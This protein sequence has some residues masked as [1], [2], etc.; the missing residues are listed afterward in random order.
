MQLFALTPEGKRKW[1]FSSDFGTSPSVGADG[2]IY[3][4]SGSGKIYAITSEGSL[5][6]SF[7]MGGSVSSPPSIAADGTIYAGTGANNWKVV[8][9]ENTLYAVRSSSWGYAAS[10]WPSYQARWM[11]HG[12]GQKGEGHSRVSFEVESRPAE[13]ERPVTTP[14]PLTSGAADQSRAEALEELRKRGIPFAPERFLECG[15]VGDVDCVK[16]FIKAGMNLDVQDEL[17]ATA[18]LR[19]LGG[20]LSALEGNQIDVAKTLLEKGANPD[21]QYKIGGTALMTASQ[22]GRLDF[23]E[24]LL[25]NNANPNVQGP[26]TALG[27]ASYA[28]HIEIVSALLEKGADPNLPG[29]SGKTALMSAS[30][31]GYTEVVK[32]LLEKGAD[33]NLR[34]DDGKTAL[35]IATGSGRRHSPK[36]YAAVIALLN[37]AAMKK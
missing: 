9:R 30:Y 10:P 12:G 13:Q 18:L 24:L 34:D 16:F 8:D 26:D 33:C 28:G 6:W 21:L 29:R 32:I 15:E 14:E 2:T 19:A 20:K 7:E 17:G 4:V 5:K 31:W 25:A 37:A 23:V 22:F 35:D 1:A 3:L 36:N 11:Q 27:A